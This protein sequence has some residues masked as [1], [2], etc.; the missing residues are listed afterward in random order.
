MKIMAPTHH[1]MANRWGE[2]GNSGRFT[3]LGSKITVDGY[4]SHENKRGLL[5]GTLFGGG[6]GIQFFCVFLP[7]LF[8]FFASIF[9]LINKRLKQ[10]NAN[11]LWDSKSSCCKINT[12]WK[13]SLT[14]KM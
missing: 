3:L 2:S 6:G 8:F 13:N 10:S 1:F 4:S 11:E 7:P 12:S 9:F 5:L 14:L